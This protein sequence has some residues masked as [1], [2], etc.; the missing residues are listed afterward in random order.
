MYCRCIIVLLR[1]SFDC[2]QFYKCTI[3]TQF[4]QI[5]VVQLYSHETVLIACSCTNV[6]L[7]DSIFTFS[8]NSFYST[9]VW[10]VKTFRTCPPK[11]GVFLILIVQYNFRVVISDYIR[12]KI[13]LS[14][15]RAVDCTVLL[16]FPVLQYAFYSYCTAAPPVLQ[17]VSCLYSTADF[18]LYYSILLLVLYCCSSCVAVQH[19]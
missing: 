5:L 8:V 7:R 10:G 2:L 15:C 18:P 3:T 9:R 19:C 17:Y 14:D 12:S 1:D 11:K 4:L 16:I 13:H 6:L